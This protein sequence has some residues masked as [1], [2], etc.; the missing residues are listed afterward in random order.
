MNPAFVY[1][2]MLVRGE[3]SDEMVYLGTPGSE[4]AHQT[5]HTSYVVRGYEY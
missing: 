5:L 3:L 1:N 2:I 4:K